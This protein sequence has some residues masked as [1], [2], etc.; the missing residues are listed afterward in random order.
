MSTNANARIMRW[1]LILSQFTYDIV[2][3]ADK[4]N[5]VADIFS[6]LCIENE[7]LLILPTIH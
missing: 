2:Y 4:N 5:H 7:F 6:H 1:A 3:K